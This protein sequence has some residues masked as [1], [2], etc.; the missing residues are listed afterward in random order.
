[1]E[2]PQDPEW[3]QL[4]AAEELREDRETIAANWRTIIELHEVIMKSRVMLE[5]TRD[6]ILTAS[7][8][9]AWTD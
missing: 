5:G 6:A 4:L 3:R 9:A 7:R 1:M 8:L 2:E